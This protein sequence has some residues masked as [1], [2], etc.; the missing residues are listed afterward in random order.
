MCLSH[1][2]HRDADSVQLMIVIRSSQ[3][4]GVNILMP[5]SSR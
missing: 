1:L 4:V 3:F 2:P 5:C